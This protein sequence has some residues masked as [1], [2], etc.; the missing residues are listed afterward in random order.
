MQHQRVDQRVHREVVLAGR[1]A[2]EAAA[3][4]EADRDAGVGI[5][6]V[7]VQAAADLVDPRVDLDRVDVLDARAQRRRDVVAAARA[8]D[9]HVL[10][11]PAAGVA[12]E[13]IRQEICGSLLPD[14]DYLLVADVVR[15][16]HPGRR[17]VDN[18][19]VG[20]PGHL[21]VLVEAVCSYGDEDQRCRGSR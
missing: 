21:T 17:R 4:V 7:G 6:L 8:D 9:H 19:V 2:R 1:G 18:L 5:G 11:R 10:E 15:V 20:R 14:F 13:Q 16:D 12:V 3:V